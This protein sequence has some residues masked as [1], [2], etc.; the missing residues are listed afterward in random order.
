MKTLLVFLLFAN[1]CLAQIE[2]GAGS[3]KTIVIDAGNYIL[4]PPPGKEQTAKELNEVRNLQAHA[5]QAA[6]DQ[7]LY[8]N[9]GAPGYRWQQIITKLTPPGP[10]AFRENALLHVAIYDATVAAWKAKYQYKRQRPGSLVHHI[11]IPDAP[12]YPCE[13]SVTAGVA[14]TILSYLYPDKADSFG[15]LAKQVTDSRIISGV[16]YPSDVVAGFELGKRIAQKVIERAKADGADLKFTGT[17]P[18]G[19][20]LWNG[21]LAVG[22]TYSKRKLWVLDSSSQ[23]RPGPPPDFGKDMA[24]LKSFTATQASQARAYFYATQ[25]DWTEITH[26]KIFEYNLE[27]NAPK[28]ALIYAVKSIAFHDALVSCWEAKYH[29][30]GIRPDQFD[31][32]Y[33]PTLGTPPFPGY[34][35]GHATTSSAV[36]TVL[37]YFFPAD[38][39]EFEH[40]AWECAESRFE[41]GIHFRTDNEV[42]L[43][44]GK[45]IGETVI[46]KTRQAGILR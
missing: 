6:I 30:W 36:A 27:H 26:R 19:A 13:Y 42:G 20:G 22:A 28:A 2:P 43:R 29:Y 12:S 37:A 21:K 44:M 35:S 45:Q 15:Q 14:S 41:G 38:K 34:P 31:T 16:Q 32:S 10:P 25:D 23:F 4:P 46:S 3:W 1:T 9:A 39:K 8:W 17:I 5:T 18:S 24:E 11:S 7:L 40:H 33:H